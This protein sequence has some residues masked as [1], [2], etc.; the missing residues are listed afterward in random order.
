[1]TA[2]CTVLVAAADVLAPAIER[3]NG[4]AV[5]ELLSFSDGEALR[6]L[7]AIIVRRPQIVA[8]ERLF[9][10]TARGAALINR[11][12]ADPTLGEVEIRLVSHNTDYHRI[13]RPATSRR[14]S[15]PAAAELPAVGAAVAVIE[16]PV[17][18]SASAV[19]PAPTPAPLPAGDAPL[20]YRGTRRAPRIRMQSTSIMLVD[21]SQARLI[22]LSRLGAQVVS[23]SSIKPNKRVRLS[24]TD[25]AGVLRFSGV[26]VWA[27]FEIPPTVGPQYRAGIEFSDPDT[28]ELDAYCERHKLITAC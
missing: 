5:G 10:S 22:D 26:V 14:T 13:A 23:G 7:E 19:L 20:D 25:E 9:A 17:V 18:A 16:H 21:G 24:L 15:A 12:K 1:V 4:A 28:A 2:A 27:S 3:L 8:V 11:V 6:A